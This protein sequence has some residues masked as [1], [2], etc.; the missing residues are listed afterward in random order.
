MATTYALLHSRGSHRRN[1]YV[2][3][4]LIFVM[5]Q[6]VAAVIAGGLF[7]RTCC[8]SPGLFLLV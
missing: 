1:A 4:L 3:E 8:L 5:L 7:T 2:R 6:V